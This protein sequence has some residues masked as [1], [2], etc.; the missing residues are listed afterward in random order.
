MVFANVWSSIL[1]AQLNGEQRTEQPTCMSKR[2]N[3]QY[4]K[5]QIKLECPACE[6]VSVYEV[7][8]KDYA[9]RTAK[10]GAMVSADINCEECET[11]MPISITF[12]Y[13]LKA[14]SWSNILQITS[15][16]EAK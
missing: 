1:P 14:E 3:I 7:D 8:A 12:G 15:E 4:Q 6:M 11:E 10:E 5:G 13:D 16:H 9:P 2:A